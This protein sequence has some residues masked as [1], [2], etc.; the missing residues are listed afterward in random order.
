LLLEPMR[1]GSAV[2]PLDVC[3]TGGGPSGDVGGIREGKLPWGT[4][5]KGL[6]EGVERDARRPASMRAP[7][8]S[9]RSGV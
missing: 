3:V 1:S 9:H 5:L 7:E 6:V 2:A 4:R 8:Y